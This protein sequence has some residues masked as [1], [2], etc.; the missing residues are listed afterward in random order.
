MKRIILLI[1]I[2]T[3]LSCKGQTE[4]EEVVSSF[5]YLSEEV[6]KTKTEEDLRLV[7]NEVFA[8]KGYV[9]KSEDL[10]YYFKTK[11]W[12]T[13][14]AN[15]EITL[16]DE[17]QHYIDKVKSIENQFSVDG[18]KNCLYY[19]GLN[20][21]DFF[22]LTSDKLLN[23]KFRDDLERIKLKVLNEVVRGNLCGGGSVW[24]IM[25]YENIKYLLLFYTCDS[26][27]LYMKMAIVKNEEVIEF[28]QLFGSSTTLN[29]DTTTDGYYDIDFKL[30]KDTLE[31]FK[32]YKE[33]AYKNS[34]TKEDSYK[35]KE[36]RR[37]VTKYKL[38]ENG[39]V[40]F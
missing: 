37:E 24:D 13:P 27:N 38:T 30:N 20:N 35:T 23:N 21:T 36:V 29:E 2:C 6:L 14:N 12:Y 15:I 17:E 33:L 19:L 32:I 7:R 18:N 1:L 5:E 39:L 10:N 4:K 31:V 8:R 26:D 40:E 22:P 34:E 16:S 3:F 25:Y 11:T 28:K 9:F